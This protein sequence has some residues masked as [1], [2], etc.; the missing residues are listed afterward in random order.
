ML[1]IEEIRALLPKDRTFT[2]EEV[3]RIREVEYGLA[4]AIFEK[5]LSEKNANKHADN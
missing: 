3:E 2:D 4:D 5:W 1:S